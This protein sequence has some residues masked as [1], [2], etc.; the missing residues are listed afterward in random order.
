MATTTISPK[1]QIVIPKE[2]RD[3]APSE[4]SAALAGRGEGRGHHPGA[5]S[6]SQIA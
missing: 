1:F 4:S 6:A 5:R 3:R 2:V